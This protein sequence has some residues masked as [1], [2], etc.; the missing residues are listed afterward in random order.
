MGIQTK[1]NKRSSQPWRADLNAKRVPW[2]ARV[3][4]SLFNDSQAVKVALTANAAQN[5]VSLTV[6]A[7]SD[8]IPAGT[9]LR[10]AAGKYAYTTAA[11]A[12]AAVAIPV[13]AL[14]VALANGDMAYYKTRSAVHIPGGTAVGRTIAERDAKAPFGPAVNTDDEIYLIYEDIPDATKDATCSLMANGEAVKENY[15]P[16]WTNWAANLKT[17]VRAKYQLTIGETS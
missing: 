12:K 17:V 6:A 2:P 10:F 5:A 16:D 3:D 11:V 9:L 15:L 1:P 4:P 8:A 13:E 7:L 14:P